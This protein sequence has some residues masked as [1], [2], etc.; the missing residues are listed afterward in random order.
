MKS[1]FLFF[2]N[3]VKSKHENIKQSRESSWIFS[4]ELNIFVL[5]QISFNKLIRTLNSGEFI[6]SWLI[7]IIFFIFFLILLIWVFLLTDM[8]FWGLIKFWSFK[9]FM[10]WFFFFYFPLLNQM[11]RL[12]R[13][14]NFTIGTFEPTIRGSKID[15]NM[16]KLVIMIKLNWVGNIFKVTQLIILDFIIIIFFS[17]LFESVFIDTL[18]CFGEPLLKC[19]LI[20]IS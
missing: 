11:T 1:N 9:F 15:G 10:W 7:M 14:S 17:F 18:I 3:H 5:L 16:M 12:S 4:P 13:L 2:F 8:I 6:L 19:L 20:F